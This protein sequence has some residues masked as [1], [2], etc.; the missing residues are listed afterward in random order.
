MRSRYTW[1][2]YLYNSRDAYK[3]AAEE[4]VGANIR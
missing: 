3:N 1:L 4:V 2:Y